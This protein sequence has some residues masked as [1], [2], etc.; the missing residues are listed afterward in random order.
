MKTQNEVKHINGWE[1]ES[2][3]NLRISYFMRT[4]DVIRN[5]LSHL[6]MCRDLFQN[7]ALVL[8][9]QERIEVLEW[10][11]DDRHIYKP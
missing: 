3:F 8:K 6:I 10:V 7:D 5:E 4:E 1:S 2:W 9:Y 11:L